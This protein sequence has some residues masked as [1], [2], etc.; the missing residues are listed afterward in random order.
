MIYI[1]LAIIIDQIPWDNAMNMCLCEIN[2]PVPN[3][4]YMHRNLSLKVTQFSAD[5]MTPTSKIYVL[6]TESWL[7]IHCQE[8]SIFPHHYHVA[9]FGK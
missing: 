4:W 3:V 6:S 2:G 9:Q 7:Q 5:K 8:S 1:S